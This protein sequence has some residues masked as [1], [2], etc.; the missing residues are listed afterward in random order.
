MEIGQL[1]SKPERKSH[2]DAM[3]ERNARNVLFPWLILRSIYFSHSRL[4][5]S[6][7]RCQLSTWRYC[8]NI[9]ANL[10]KFH[11][12]HTW[13]INWTSCLNFLT[14]KS[15]IPRFTRSHLLPLPAPLIQ[16]RIYFYCKE[17]NKLCDWNPNVTNNDTDVSFSDIKRSFPRSHPVKKHSKW[18]WK[19]SLWTRKC[20]F[21]VY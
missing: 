21:D 11:L 18:E 14:Q 8:C 7:P 6:I 19:V 2:R 3:L 17:C 12:S 5:L 15:T 13:N 4:L 20:D 9:T 1:E 16:V 10:F